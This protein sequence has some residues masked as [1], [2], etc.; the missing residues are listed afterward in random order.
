MSIRRKHPILSQQVP[1]KI[2]KFPP[3][4]PLTPNREIAT[5][6]SPFRL[7]SLMI[8]STN[9]FYWLIF[10]GICAQLSCNWI[11]TNRPVPGTPP[12][13]PIINQS[14]DTASIDIFIVRLAPH[15]N[16]LLQQLW[17]EVDEQSLPPQLRRELFAQGFRVGILG[18]L[19]SPALAQ[20]L[21]ITADGRTDIQGGVQEISVADA[22]REPT[23]TRNAR[24]L[25]PGMSA[26]VRI[27]D[28]PLPEQSLFWETNGMIHGQTYTDVL[29]LLNVRAT[30]NKDGSA[31]IQIVPELE[32]GTS[33]LRVRPVSGMVVHETGKPRHSFESLTV[34]QRL[35][36][37]Q[38]LIMGA[39]AIDS[40]GVGKTFF[41]R[42]NA[43]QEQRLLAIRLISVTPAAPT[44]TAAPQTALWGT[45]TSMP[46][47]N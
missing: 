14:V 30:A 5:I 18:S 43:G 1:D 46:E 47:R 2:P 7:F 21:T 10:G 29:G 4:L 39:T 23:V 36:P 3:K 11:G 28:T 45:E 44:S 22:A 15:Q 9:L 6:L 13:T 38:W 12:P 17:Q 37:G 26:V 41:V 32:H 19:L 25:L 40:P 20:L 33:E 16:A 8:K 31:L 27:F 34:P 24:N 42:R 35:L